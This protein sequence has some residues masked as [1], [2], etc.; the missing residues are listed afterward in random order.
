MPKNLKYRPITALVAARCRMLGYSE[1]TVDGY[2]S[3]LAA[4]EDWCGVDAMQADQAQASAWLTAQRCSRNTLYHNRNALV[5]L[6]RSM[7][8]QAIDPQVLPAVRQDRPRLVVVPDPW[9]VSNLLAAITDLRCRIFCQFLYAT[10][11]RLNEARAVQ[12]GDLD[13]ADRSLLVRFG[14][15]RRSRR[16]IL[17]D[18]IIAALQAY[19]RACAPS[20]LLFPNAACQ[21]ER[22]IAEG[23]V[24]L[25]LA[26]ARRR[27]GLACQVTAHRLRHCFATHLHERGAG[28][29]EIQRLLGH[30][31]IFSTLRYLGMR[32]ERRSELCVIGDLIAALPAPRLEQQRILFS[33]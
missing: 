9:Q 6:F 19:R 28:V 31:S 1:R 17:P 30:A 14:K 18:G 22:P 33:A 24:N 29:F 10:G 23:R 5:F 3:R 11:L 27:C 2:A 20:A 7:R 4:F 26:N 12:I 32:E 8:R 13:L 15:G 25:A 21:P 16:T